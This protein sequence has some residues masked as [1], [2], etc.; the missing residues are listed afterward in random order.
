MSVNIKNMLRPGWR[1][2]FSCCL[3]GLSAILYSI[4]FLIFKDSHHIFLY[5]L[6]DIAFVPISVLLVTLVLE[7]ILE[8][9]Q[10]ETIAHKLNMVLGTFFS[11]VGQ[12][13]LKNLQQ[14]I[15]NAQDIHQYLQISTDWNLK[16]F[17]A[18]KKNIS[19]FS[20]ELNLKKDSLV[21]LRNFLS[22]KRHFLLILLENPNLL[23]HEKITDMLWAIFHVTEE[24]EA[25]RNLA[26]IGGK[27]Q[28]HLTID[29]KR[30][31]GQLILE[32]IE[33]M[34]YLKNDYP[35]LFS[36]A[37]RTNPFNPQAQAEIN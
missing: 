6:G 21:E 27:D 2:I 26:N 18:A 25:R 31:Y 4:H 13:L 36:L 37:V 12:P 7:Q 30:V 22:Q 32:W 10:K 9:R 8:S 14:F 34:K 16:N 5:L 29:L 19:S 33:Y 3:L 17:A 23:E 35:Y 15:L 24:L 20:F 11:E 1:F 28:E